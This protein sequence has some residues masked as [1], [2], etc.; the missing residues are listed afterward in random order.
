MTDPRPALPVPRD[1]A[2]EPLFEPPIDRIALLEATR[3]YY[4]AATAFSRFKRDHGCR[5]MPRAEY[6]A[7]ARAELGAF[8]ALKKCALPADFI[9]ETYEEASS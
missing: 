7:L 8:T 6:Q 4:E 1:A 5:R 9:S 2:A 3:A